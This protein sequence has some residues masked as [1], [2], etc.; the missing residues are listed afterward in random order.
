MSETYTAQTEEGPNG[1]LVLPF[2]EKMMEDL[3]W[4]VGDRLSL[5]ANDGVITITNVSKAQRNM[6]IF[7]VETISS[8]RHRYAV[9]AKCGEHAADEVV[10]YQVPDEMSQH[11]VGEQVTSTRQI[12]EEEYLA[13]FDQ[14]NSYQ[15][16]WTEERKKQFIHTINYDNDTI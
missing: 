10:L 16:S 15:S 6:P 2:P 12:T 7:I 14:D 8:F 5:S 1:S 11:H 9:R 4:Q 3:Q 13:L